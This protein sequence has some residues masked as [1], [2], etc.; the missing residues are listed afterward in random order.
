MRDE[1]GR[2]LSKRHDSMSLRQL[3]AQNIEPETLRKQW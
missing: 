1:Q 3:R 2:R